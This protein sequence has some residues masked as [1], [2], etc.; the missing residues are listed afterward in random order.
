M[1]VWFFWQ[2]D[3]RFEPLASRGMWFKVL[4][5]KHGY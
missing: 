5:A 2:H 1:S 3:V 4:H